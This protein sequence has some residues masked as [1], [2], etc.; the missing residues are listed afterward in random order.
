V[1]AGDS[2]RELPG[3]TLQVLLLVGLLVGF[4]VPWVAWAESKLAER[5]G[6]R[7]GLAGTRVAGLSLAGLLQPLADGLKLLGKRDLHPPESV[8][9]ARVWIPLFVV[10]PPL[11]AFAAIPFGGAY[12]FGETSR[13]IVL[14]DLEV[15]ILFIFALAALGAL[16][17]VWAGLAS[18][19]RALLA[20]LRSAGLGLSGDL[21][22]FFAVLPMLLIFGS[23][24][25]A[26]IVQGQDSSFAIF[27]FWNAV[28]AG[29]GALASGGP[30]WPAWGIFLNPPAFVLVLVAASVRM[31]LPPFDG[32]RVEAELVGG[33]RAAYS[34]LALGLFAV[35]ARLQTLL[36]AALLTLIFLGGWTIP[37]LSQ[38]ELVDGIAHWIGSGMANG[39]CLVVH[40]A[41]FGFKL[42]AMV[43]L[44]LMIRSAL[45]RLGYERAMDLCWKIIVPASL[46]DLVLTAGVMHVLGGRGG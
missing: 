19:G 5:V 1:N 29:P 33:T 17:T 38:A 10:L 22:L 2:T 42:L 3:L 40:L 31:G 6:G 35:A 39:L 32:E 18:G 13:S 24:R 25:L 12:V 21:A 15:G 16:A 26:E 28:V 11:L 20:A 9:G 30:T 14:A 23:L 8:R 27:G 46:I 4:F 7:P 34:G 41:S 37:W 44:L 43:F 45:P 36:L